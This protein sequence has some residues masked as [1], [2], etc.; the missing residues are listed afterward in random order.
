MLKLLAQV[1]FHQEG[2]KFLRWYHTASDTVYTEGE[3]RYV[4]VSCFG[5]STSLT[6]A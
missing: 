1:K 5:E 4:W 6:Q 3:D 2:L